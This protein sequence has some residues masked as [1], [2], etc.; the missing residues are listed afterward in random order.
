MK[1]YLYFPNPFVVS[2]PVH[3]SVSS[4]SSNFRCTD[5]F[6]CTHTLPLHRSFPLHAHDSAA[7]ITF[8]SHTHTFLLHT[9]TSAARTRTSAA[10]IH[11]RCTH[12]HFRYTRHSRCTDALSPNARTCGNSAFERRSALGSQRHQRR[13][14]VRPR[15]HHSGHRRN[16]QRQIQR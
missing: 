11:F 2:P 5:L 7:S 6:R 1:F 9:Y 12:T 15:D 3:Q 10:H 4:S 13:G 16:R 14:A 8:T